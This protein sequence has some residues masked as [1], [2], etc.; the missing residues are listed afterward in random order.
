MEDTE[1]DFLWDALK[2]VRVLRFVAE[3]GSTTGWRGTGAGAVAVMSPAPDV[4]MFAETGTWRTDTGVAPA[5]RNTYR[6]TRLPT[7]LRLEHL[8]FGE[9]APVYLFDL[10]P[11]ESGVWVSATPHQCRADLYHA[12]LTRGDGILHLDWTVSGAHK[13]E[14]VACTYSSVA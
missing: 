7:S 14:R 11:Q 12:R 6:W 13:S 4:L 2:S 1:L 10:M 9:S 8:R 3:S 5:F